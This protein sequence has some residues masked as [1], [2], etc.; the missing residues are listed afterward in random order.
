MFNDEKEAADMSLTYS[1]GF[2]RVVSI[3]ILNS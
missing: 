1:K 2:I 3:I